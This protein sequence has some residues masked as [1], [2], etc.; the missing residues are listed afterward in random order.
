MFLKI[1]LGLLCGILLGFVLQRGRFCMVSAYRDV[2]LTKDSRLFIATL[3]AIVVQSIGVYALASLGVI[4]IGQVP[5]TWLAAILGGF[6]FGVGIVLASGCATGTWYRSG[7]GLVGSW[8]ALFGYALG[9]AATKFGALKPLN[10]WLTAPQAKHTYVYETLGVSPW[11]LIILLTA[12]TGYVVWRHLQ[13]KSVLVPTPRPRKT[14]LAHILFEKRWHPFATGALVGLIAILAWPMS[15]ATGRMFGLGITTP[16]GQLLQYLVTGNT[17]VLNWGVFLVLGIAVG[18]FIAAKGSGEFRW[19]VPDAKTSMRSLAGG[20]VM[21]FGAG[22]AGGCTV[23]NGLVNTALWTWEGWVATPF[24]I[25]GT[26]FMTYWTMVRPQRKTR[27]LRLAGKP[28][29]SA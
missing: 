22:I 4:Q 7:E 20:V 9:S 17:A 25:L 8:I 19:R 24:I 2:Y 3:I 15:E 21:G 14:G 6:L 11:G 18:S 1:S 23:G 28:V 29:A 10:D 5:F 26:W 13:Q 27:E 16:T 12:V